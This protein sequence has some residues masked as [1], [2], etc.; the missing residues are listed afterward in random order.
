MSRVSSLYLLQQTDL[1]LDRARKRLKEIE[2]M[3]NDSEELREAREHFTESKGE[4][5]A[6]SSAARSAEHAVTDQRHKIEQTETKLYGGA[7]TNPKE[8]QDLQMESESLRRHLITLE[9]RL[10]EAMVAE[11]EAEAI[12]RQSVSDL[13]EA[14]E[15]QAERFGSLKQEQVELTD[16]VSRLEEERSA[17]MDNIDDEDLETYDDLRAR[18]GG[19]ALSLLE[20]GSCSA[21][22]LSHPPSVQQ[23]VRSGGDLLRC[24]QCGR[25]LYGG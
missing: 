17:F 18:L 7:I 9:E 23:R 20:N 3:L 16:S 2:A 24:T 22:G 14:E 19:I 25:I 13:K 1:D 15:A 8:L 4:L 11:E 21:C 5:D 12:H 10:L 6:A